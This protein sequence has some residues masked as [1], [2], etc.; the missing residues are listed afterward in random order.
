MKILFLVIMAV[1]ICY[2]FSDCIYANCS[3]GGKQLIDNVRKA[4]MKKLAD[5]IWFVMNCLAF[6]AIVFFI[7]GIVWKKIF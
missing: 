1:Y 4:I 3:E 2:L 6:F 5:D 7:T